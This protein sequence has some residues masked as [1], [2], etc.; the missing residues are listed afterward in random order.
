MFE[1]GEKIVY[2]MY[3]AGIITDIEDRII[4]GKTQKYYMMKL[5]VGDLDVMLPV[6][7]GRKLGMR[8]V[9]SKE[10]ASE[11]LLFYEE[12]KPEN[13]SA[14]NK[15]YRENL[16]LLKG[17]KIQDVAVVLKTLTMLDKTKGLSSNERKMYNST[18]QIFLSE[19]A[20]ALDRDYQE[21]EKLVWNME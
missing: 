8:A 1:I 2:P 20:V 6:D 4:L 11:A 9:I 14:W 13:I 19:L 5:P 21:L 7:A 12:Y 15:R 17:G 3:G 16:L 10:E 18:K